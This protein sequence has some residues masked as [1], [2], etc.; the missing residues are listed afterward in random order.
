MNLSRFIV[1]HA[2]SLLNIPAQAMQMITAL[3][4]LSG[5]SR[6]TLPRELIPLNAMQISRGALNYALFQGLHDWVFPYAFERQLDA[7]DPSF[8]PRAHLSVMMNVTHRN[9][10]GIGNPESNSEP[11]VDP[12]GLVTVVQDGWSIDFWILHG[13]K[14]IFPS[15]SEGVQQRLVGN[16]PLVESTVVA[17]D[18]TLRTT[19]YMIGTTLYC[20]A[21][22]QRDPASPGAVALIVAIRPFNPEGAS[23]V[24]TLQYDRSARTL[25][26]NNAHKVGFFEDPDVVTLSTFEEGDVAGKLSTELPPADR[27]Q[28]RCRVGLASAALSFRTKPDEAH[29]VVR[30]QCDTVKAENGLKPFLE[31]S[32]VHAAW[33]SYREQSMD[34]QTPDD[35]LNRLFRASLST[36]IML[37]DGETIT[38][39]PFTYHQF[40]FRDAAVMLLALDKAGCSRFVD[41][42]VRSYPRRQERSGFFRSQQG[43]WDSNGQALWTMWQHS[44][45][46]SDPASELNELFRSAKRGAKWLDTAR[47]TERSADGTSTIGLLPAGLSAEHLGLV[48]YYYWDN[49]WALAGMY[50][51][52]EICRTV[53]RKE[54]MQWAEKVAGEILNDVG[55]S[56]RKATERLKERA[57]PAGPLRGYDAGM[58][59]SI[60]ALYPL[61]LISANDERIGATMEMILAKFMRGG[62]FFQDFI[63]SGLNTYLSLQLAHAMLYRGNREEANRTFRAVAERATPTLTFPEAINARTGG[64]VMGDGHHGWAAAEVVLFMREM[65]VYESWDTANG[66]FTL[67]LLAGV[68]ANWLVDGAH[69][70]VR[71]VPVPKGRLSIEVSVNGTET[72][73]SL[74][75]QGQDVDLPCIVRFPFEGCVSESV[76]VSRDATASGAQVPFRMTVGSHSIIFRR[77]A[78]ES[79]PD[80]QV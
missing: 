65:F 60:V 46:V 58:I 30:L 33:A 64:G 54:E 31:S 78:Q 48:D 76:G 8:V 4:E 38:P 16:D 13:G 44:M 19:A 20:S 47:K 41:P 11:I 80:Y 50:A 61:Q 69:F 62:M 72:K 28:V 40:W 2:A 67:I 59:G 26:I 9:W 42:I 23:L 71:S 29:T 45:Y 39:G 21:D 7:S 36:L 24:H 75:L 70:G 12:R 6:K 32:Q 18:I 43:E 52:R 37:L 56:I 17:G 10:T 3:G 15:R 55:S 68:P 5:F 51:Y 22:L 34:M 57:I 66:S 73:I 25:R 77:S 79:N 1:Q 35:S 49:Y 63:H 27:D 74:D 14:A 53:E